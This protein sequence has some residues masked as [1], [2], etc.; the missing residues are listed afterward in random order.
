MPARIQ[1]KRSKGQSGMPAGAKY[2]GRG[3][4]CRWGNPFVVGVDADDKAHATTLFLEWLA[5][6]SYDV[7]A[8]DLSAERRRDMDV[9][10]DWMLANLPKLAGRDLACWC[11]VPE[12]GLPDHCHGAV[13][14]ELANPTEET[15][16]A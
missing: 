14:L 4:G 11:A 2:V 6:N 5:N 10:R 16:N 9:R 15:R 1:R 3:K 8:P 13:L 7:H 12:P